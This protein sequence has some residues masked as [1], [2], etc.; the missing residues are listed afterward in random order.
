M[1]NFISLH[2]QTQYSILDS[3]VDVKALFLR[4]K[5]LS[6]SAIGITEHGSLGSVWEAWKAS[7]ATGVKLIIGC[8]CYFQNDISNVEDKFRHIILLAKN[9][10]GYRNLLTINKKG[11]DQTSFIG[12]RVYSV[13]DWKL[14]EQYSEG[15]VCLTACGNGIISQL[16]MQHKTNE[17]EDTLIRL[18]KI[19]GDNLG[20]E[21]QP[22]NMKRGSNIFNDE[23]D[24]FF[25]NRQLINLGKKH[26]IRVVA[27]CNTHYLT[28]EESETHD[29]FLA[30]GSHQPIYSNFRLRYTVPDFYLK[31]GD[32]VK[33]FFSRNYGDE[34]A[35]QL[36][37]N[38]IYFADLCEKPEWIDPK[39]SNPSGKELPIFPVKDEP[40][41]I[42]FCEWK[43]G[44]SED[45]KKLAED[46]AYLR[47]KSFQE[48]NKRLI[49]QIKPE[50]HDEYIKRIE[51]ELSVLDY[52]GFSSYMLIVGDYV[53][54]AKNNEVPV[55]PGRGCVSGDTLV[56][57]SNGL[58]PI[59]EIKIGEKVFTHT[60]LLKEVKNI[61]EY[62]VNETL[63][64]IKTD[65]SYE[66]TILTKDHKLLASKYIGYNSVRKVTRRDWKKLPPPTWIQVKDLDIKDLL[67]MTYP[68]INNNEKNEI[69]DLLQFVKTG[70]II[71]NKI[72]YIR[73]LPH[74]CSVPSVAKNSGV[75]V[76]TVRNIKTGKTKK[77][78]NDKMEKI[79][80][81]LNDNELSFDSWKK[82]VFADTFT[83]DKYLELDAAF[84]YVFG[85]WVGDG[86]IING[87][88]KK[89]IGFSFHK[90]EM[91]LVNS[92]IDYFH[93]K[94]FGGY[95]YEKIE[96]ANQVE[97]I[98][99]VIQKLFKHYCNEY[100]G[101]SD[102]KH[103][104]Y[105]FRSLSKGN[106]R[107]LLNGVLDSDGHYD[108][109]TNSAC[110]LI[111]TSKR[112]AFEIKE[113]LLMLK[114]SSSILIHY[115]GGF[116]KDGS[117]RKISYEVFIPNNE[118]R[119]I[120]RYKENG[121]YCH[122]KNIT[123][124]KEDKVYDIEVEDDHSYLTSNFA[125]HNSGSGSMIGYLLG[126]HEADPIKYNLIFER[127]QN[128]NKLSPP[129]LDLDF[130]AK[131]RYKV[132]DYI[133]KKYG[134]DNVA[135]VSNF[136]T[137]TPKVYVR[138][139][140]RSC[141][142]GGSKEEAVKIGTL[143]ADIIPSEIRNKAGLEAIPL[144][145]E[146]AKRYPELTKH[147]NILGKIRNLSTHAAAIVIGGRP[148]VGLFPLRRDK[149]GSLSLECEKNTTEEVG[150]VKMD[151][152][153]V[154]TLDI[155]EQC[156]ILIKEAG[157]ELPIINYDDND[158]KTYEL[159]TKGDTYGVFQFGTSG[160]TID[161]CKKIKPKN[162]N[163]L[164]II[165]TLARPAASDIRKDFISAR[166]GKTTNT[167][168]HPSLAGAFEKTYGF[169]LFDESILRLG[170]DVAG[171][172]LNEAD[173][174][175]KMIKD[176]GKYPDK[177]KKLREEFIEGA[178]KNK[179]IRREIAVLIWDNEI[180]KFG[181]YTF[182]SGHATTYSMI[183]YHTAFLKA[184]YPIE[185][186]M[187][188]LMAEVKSASDDARGNID[189]I[190]GELKKH[191]VKVIS[192]DINKSQLAY[193]IEEG[194]KLITGLD[195]IKFVG[196]DAIIDI[197]KKRPFSNF[198]D[199]MS[200]VTS[201]AVR[202]NSIQA[203]AACGALDS[204]KLPRRYMFLY[205]SDYRKKLQI[206]LKKHD[207][208]K[209]QFV[210]PWPVE[211]DWSVQELYALEQYYLGESFIC[212]P[213]AAYGNFFK[214]DHATV[215]DIK[216]S[217][218]K[219][220]INSVKGIVT[221]FFE[222]RVKKETSKFYGKPMV[223]AVIEDKNGATITLTIFSDKWDIVKE[224]V[225]EINKKAVFSV[226]MALHFSGN[227]NVYEDDIGI[228]LNDL[229]DIALPPALPDDL[230]AKKINLKE[231]KAKIF[232]KEELKKPSSVQEIEDQM[233][234]SLYDE[235]LIDLD[236]ELDIDY[237]AEF[238]QNREY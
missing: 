144:Y 122:I 98:N 134:K 207:P 69:I 70:K 163:D 148:L 226:G 54:W 51:T 227:T 234:D 114:Q 165:T 10:A 150:F 230:K 195:A 129:D 19:F 96:K 22:N 202:A 135:Y 181:S 72:I 130:G 189:K 175:R 149:D 15:L 164:S 194:N 99:E 89:G 50:Q 136:N 16:L 91:D 52:Q 60:G 3:L 55:G 21:V 156:K 53:N 90:D 220:N 42:E 177:D 43:E 124:V 179:G 153:G 12:K 173:R 11:F 154:S 44:Q 7:Q 45:I 14:L 208:I 27:A 94:G 34:I 84:Y 161:L 75:S 190:K 233:E 167:L 30:I 1:T 236:E 32:E 65:L 192:P 81:Y 93:S 73:H 101:S 121:Y 142:F 141:E 197:I 188:N 169:G 105:N 59:K 66:T 139:I 26:N 127:F 103:L 237:E 171:W 37:D 110:H 186:L 9:A 29:V 100:I 204:F 47:F 199:F 62:D 203:L 196:D 97:I 238:T 222:F 182:N 88:H 46:S 33:A 113:L 235:G 28:K 212:K 151:I 206:W 140:A 131:N 63:L 174:L 217:K 146:H 133:I 210:Y 221:N 6:M 180:K 111:T 218:N 64:N 107:A 39:F 104:P 178:I 106:L 225:K 23:I 80:N 223:K 200:R 162:I 49:H 116:G 184:H 229:F 143:I 85:L 158:E 56:F 18:K 213:A 68:I 67:W 185:F 13:I 24:Q 187:A 232:N 76:D 231:A 193:T 36:C 115:K 120:H 209:D 166:E 216:K 214:S 168:L 198:F 5:E 128:K 4:A 79:V 123:E 137:I 157:K 176:K 109:N 201:K 126:I 112:L 102:T 172:D 74:A 92:V 191:H 152:L 183:S 58:K 31:T 108:K 170:A 25:L 95:Y 57:T 119:S 118:K 215:Y 117:M 78:S 228:I 8:E 61:F 132:I 77:I 211:P 86:W 2:N 48:F 125:S 145:Y 224:R 17:A 83:I 219:S 82:A 38:S 87:S 40:D 35:Q 147:S 138:D 20:I 71:D 155:I 205:C 41:Y 160:G 159:I